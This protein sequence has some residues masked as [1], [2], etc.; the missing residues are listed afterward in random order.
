M[1]SLL[2]RAAGKQ[3]RAWGP[4]LVPEGLAGPSAFTDEGMPEMG[5]GATQSSS[6]SPRF[7][8]PSNRA[9]GPGLRGAG[10]SQTG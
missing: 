9:G 7:G 2:C 8:Q 1:G 4:I 3:Q 10:L 5:M 6:Q